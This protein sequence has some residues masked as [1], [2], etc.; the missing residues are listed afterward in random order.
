MPACSPSGL[1][2][3]S[4]SLRAAAAPRLILL[5][6]TADRLWPPHPHM[7]R[8]VSES[9][10][11][12]YLPG[13]DPEL[14]LRVETQLPA[15]LP[16]G[17]RTAVF[18]YGSCFHRRLKVRRI[19]L[20]AG[21]ATAA[22]T[23]RMPRA[24]IHRTLHPFEGQSGREPEDAESDDPKSHSY[25]SG[26]WATLPIE[27]PPRRQ[28]RGGS[29]GNALGWLPGGDSDRRDP[30]WFPLRSRIRRRRERA[31]ASGA[32]N[33]DRYGQLRPRPRPLPRPDRFDPEPDPVATG[34]A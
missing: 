10:S 3:P 31:A 29:A 6:V 20:T 33:R 12:R 24:D 4:T 1:A 25:R 18:V 7:I 2:D 11:D 9:A 32:A 34:S 5:D 13:P 28:P 27:M 19:E 14:E 30:R 22:A 26:F 17:T 8:A 16:A 23:V 21:D 15:G